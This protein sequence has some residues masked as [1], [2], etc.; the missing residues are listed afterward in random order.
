M[1]E[2]PVAAYLSA[3]PL[4]RAGEIRSHLALAHAVIEGRQSGKIFADDPDAPREILV[5]PA[6]GFCFVFGDPEGGAFERFLPKFL[7]RHLPGQPELFGASAAWQ[8]LLDRHFAGHYERTGFEL[9][10]GWEDA[11]PEEEALPSGM[12]LVP[13]D[14]AVRSA[15][16]EGLDPWIWRIW[17]G[18]ERFAARSFG[19]AI[20]SEGAPVSFCA[21]CGIG[22][23]EAEVEVGTVPGE[24]GRGLARRA[25]RAFMRE[26]ARRGLRPAWSC[27]ARNAPSAAL[28]RRLGFVAIETIR[29]YPLSSAMRLEEGRWQAPG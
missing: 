20:R 27:A 3:L 5:A 22:D 4:I 19:F 23:G 11:L 15:W 28:G 8:A 16:P 18:P 9:P 26:C 29:G 6:T 12:S 17:G 14:A 25:A 24:Q 7:A 13:M 10:A 21:A 1:I 2:L